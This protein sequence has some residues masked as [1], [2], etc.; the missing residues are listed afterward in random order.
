[1]IIVNFFFAFID[2]S[3]GCINLRFFL[4]SYNCFNNISAFTLLSIDLFGG[5]HYSVVESFFDSRI[6]LFFGIIGK[7]PC[8]IYKF[9]KDNSRC[10][11]NYSSRTYELMLL[12]SV[13]HLDISFLSGGGL[14]SFCS[15]GGNVL[16]IG[17]DD[18][19]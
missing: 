3:F 9:A 11:V 14:F 12:K 19:E 5:I 15:F 17:N 6:S 7:M 1:M 4:G 10:M 13:D 8:F 18:L 16:Q 2:N